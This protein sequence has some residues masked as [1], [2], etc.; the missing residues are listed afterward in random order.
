MSIS[1]CT[2]ELKNVMQVKAAP[3]NKVVAI[4]LEKKLYNTASIFLLIW[5]TDVESRDFED[6]A[7][8]LVGLLSIN[9]PE[10]KQSN[11]EIHMNLGI[12][13]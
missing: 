6:E 13:H 11:E 10:S 3:D 1:R 4:A 7:T 5:K 2:A 9:K 12:G 8:E